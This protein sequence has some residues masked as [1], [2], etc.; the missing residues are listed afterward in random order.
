MNESFKVKNVVVIR[1]TKEKDA[2]R[3][4]IT[5][6]INNDGKTT[7]KYLNGVFD[8]EFRIES[9]IVEHAYY[10]R[11]GDLELTFAEPYSLRFDPAGGRCYIYKI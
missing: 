9:L 8:C 6:K 1:F 7:E 2:F 4:E 3:L 11:D 5:E 10:N